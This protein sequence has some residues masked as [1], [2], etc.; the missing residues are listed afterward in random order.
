MRRGIGKSR[1][2][3]VKRKRG[4]RCEKYAEVRQ[5]DIQ[6]KNWVVNQK[7]ARKNTKSAKIKQILRYNGGIKYRKSRSEAQISRW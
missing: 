5:Q 3:I 4:T 2:K 7:D 1:E 6:G